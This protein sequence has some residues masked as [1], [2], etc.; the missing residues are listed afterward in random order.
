SDRAPGL[1]LGPVE[2]LASAARRLRAAQATSARARGAVRRARAPDALAVAARAGWPRPG[3]GPRRPGSDRGLPGPLRRVYGSGAR[4]P[5]Q[6]RAPRP[7]DGLPQGKRTDRQRAP[8]LRDA[9]GAEFAARGIRPHR[10]RGHVEAVCR[11]GRPSLW[12]APADPP[13]YRRLPSEERGGPGGDI[14]RP[15]A[16]AH[17]T[18]HARSI[19]ARCAAPR[20]GRV[21]DIHPGPPLARGVRRGRPRRLTVP[22]GLASERAVSISSSRSGDE[23]MDLAT[24]C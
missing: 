18:A 3:V 21:P 7:A 5:G 14:R 22:S 11:A 8:A 12:T 10:D 15:R 4:P 20:A 9:G 24:M 19:R 2:G 17:H 1:A 23:A 16:A 6:W 13:R